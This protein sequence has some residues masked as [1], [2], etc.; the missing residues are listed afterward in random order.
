MSKQDYTISAD[1]VEAVDYEILVIGYPKNELEDLL[2]NLVSERGRIARS[3]YEDF[4]IAYCIANLNQFMAHITSI[5]GAGTELDLLL[6]RE[7]VVALVLKYN[8][9]LRPA[10][11]IINKNKVLK[12]RT[13]DEA[14]DDS[15][16]L[17]DNP[18]WNQSLYDKEGNYTPIS[19]NPQSEGSI[20]AKKGRSGEAVAKSG[21]KKSKEKIEN[22][23]ELSYEEV[24]VWWERCNEYVTIKQYS[25]SDIDKILTFRYFHNNMSFDTF[26]I[27]HCISN[28]EEIYERIEGM[29]V[30]IAPAKIVSELYV[31]CKGVNPSLTF[32]RFKELREEDDEV[33]TLSNSSGNSSQATQPTFGFGSARKKEKKLSFKDV[34]KEDLLALNTNM[35]VALVGQDEAIDTLTEAIK[36]ASVGL[37]DPARPIGSFLFAGRT[38]CG[39]TISSKVLA[40]SLIR[41]RKN[42]IVIDC[43]EYSSDHEYAKLIGAPAGYMGHEQ[44][45]NLTNAIVE[46]PFSVVVFDE[47][48]KASSKV[49]D[50][51]LQILDEGRLTDGKGV[52]VT[53]KDAIIIMTSNIG[54]KEVDDVGKT[55]GFGDVAKL[56]EVKKTKALDEALK[57]KFKPEFLNRI[58]SIVH[59]KDLTDDDYMKIISL[60]LDKLNNNLK[61]NS[62]DYRDVYLTFDDKIKEFI[63]DKGVDAKY[64]ARPIKRAI[65]K[66]ISN[67][68]AGLLLETDAETLAEIKVTIV[69]GKVKLK[70]IKVRKDNASLLMHVEETQ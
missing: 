8:E 20:Y 31:L 49:Y 9:G 39:K 68:V 38:G 61:A 5:T 11:I 70:P 43:S 57:K 60:E 32:S 53:F 1:K 51:L 16:I 63:F 59:F 55:I 23:S 29:G 12:L 22:L 47:I 46:D 18:F 44:G 33:E 34:P 67:D 30:S 26:V 14:A 66:Y 56:T 2:T 35:K 24:R 15:Q 52:S 64:G 17:T 65:E 41:T 19:K 21:I 10:N 62:T 27:S 37:K 69:R 7:E 45:G 4:L 13:G 40:D 25:T 48:E 58:D 6:V 36:R 50:L 28:I 42:R 3:R 54:V